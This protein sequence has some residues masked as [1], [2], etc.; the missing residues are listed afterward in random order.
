A[1]VRRRAKGVER[2]A[3]PHGGGG[4]RAPRESRADRIAAGANSA[5]QSTAWL[6][7][8][9]G[10][11]AA[12]L[13]QARLVDRGTRLGGGAAAPRSPNAPRPRRGALGGTRTAAHRTRGPAAGRRARRR[14]GERVA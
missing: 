1:R 12:P 3:R 11:P 9:L 4:G 6:A 2:S 5:E 8:H 10:M 7:R 14:A 13:S